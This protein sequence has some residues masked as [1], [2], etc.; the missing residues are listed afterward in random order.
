M[1]TYSIIDYVLMIKKLKKLF[2][3]LRVINSNPSVIGYILQHDNPTK[4]YIEKKYGP[5]FEL[6]RIDFLELLPNCKEIIS[7]FASLAHGSTIMDYVLLKGLARKYPNCRYLE[8]G[9]WMGESIVNVSNVANE[10]VSI[11]LSNEDL[12]KCNANEKELQVQRFFSKKVHN[13]QH[14]MQDSQHFDFSTIGKFDL[15]FIDGD[16]SHKAVKHD[17]QNA[18]KVLKDE[19]S[20]IIWHDY[21]NLSGEAINW[22]IFA[23][24][25]DGCPE[26][27]RLNLFHVSNTMCAIFT[28]KKFKTGYKDSYIPNKKFNVEISGHYLKDFEN[29]L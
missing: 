15:V 9:T 5:K 13:I 14:I 7:P 3:I 18:F 24:I 29:R 4:K 2:K 6:P 23:G 20:I 21:S 12:K 16:H 28:L 26:E 19:N 25:M 27:Y 1:F 17:T 8:I 10:C 11:S 22:G